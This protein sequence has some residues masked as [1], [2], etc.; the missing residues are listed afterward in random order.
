MSILE[1]KV[2]VGVDVASKHLDLFIPDTGK[3]ERIE[4]YTDAVNDLCV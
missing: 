4:N 1:S 3:A 2:Y